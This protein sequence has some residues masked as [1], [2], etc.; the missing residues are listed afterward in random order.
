MQAA[1]A[2]PFTR[3][4]TPFSLPGADEDVSLLLVSLPDQYAHLAEALHRLFQGELAVVCLRGQGL[5]LGLPH[6][7]EPGFH[8]ELPQQQSLGSHPPERWFHTCTNRFWRG[9]L[10]AAAAAAAAAGGHHVPPHAALEQ[11][12][13][14]STHS[15]ALRGGQAWRATHQQRRRQQRQRQR[16]TA[17]AAHPPAGRGRQARAPPQ[18]RPPAVH[19]P[20]HRLP[21][22]CPPQE[23]CGSAGGA[24]PAGGWGVLRRAAGC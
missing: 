4:R 20:H 15:G 5:L 18:P 19:Q 23:R 3:H 10:E 16:H 24:F 9:G 22:V 7:P 1:P 2:V 13:S 12:H 6:K 14:G 21:G 8:A 11:V 17:A